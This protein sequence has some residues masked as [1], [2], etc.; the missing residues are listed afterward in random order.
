M[1]DLQGI[2]KTL[3]KVGQT[4]TPMAGQLT[5]AGKALDGLDADLTASIP[6]LDG[7]QQKMQG[8]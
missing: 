1:A 8:M 4:L 2:Q 3:E 7:M 6:T 5:D